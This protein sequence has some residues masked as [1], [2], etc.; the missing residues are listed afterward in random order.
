MDKTL[1]DPIPVAGKPSPGS[2]AI[3][4]QLADSVAMTDLR[5]QVASLQR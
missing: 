4:E 3:A 2:V 1:A 5:S